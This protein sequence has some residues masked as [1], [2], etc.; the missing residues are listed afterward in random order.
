MKTEINYENFLKQINYARIISNMIKSENIEKNREDKKRLDEKTGLNFDK[1]IDFFINY[2]LNSELLQIKIKNPHNINYCNSK[3]SDI[4]Y[5]L[6]IN[7]VDFISAYIISEHVLGLDAFFTINKQKKKL[8]KDIRTNYE[9]KYLDF[10][11]NEINNH[12]H[13]IWLSVDKTKK[14]NYRNKSPYTT[15]IANVCS[16]L[17]GA[18]IIPVS[19]SL[20]FINYRKAILFIEIGRPIVLTSGQFPTLDFID[21]LDEEHE[22]LKYSQENQL[23]N[24]DFCGYDY[25]LKKV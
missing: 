18:N 22:F 21:F 8:R 7:F 19:H 24:N 11:I 5:N 12:K 4:F 6:Q 13:S 2:L 23:I 9:N 17:D 16:K 14:R 20:K 15:N 1:I 3:Y 10:L 25:V